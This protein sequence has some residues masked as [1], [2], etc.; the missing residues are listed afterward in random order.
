LL[1]IFMVVAGYLMIKSPP[2]YAENHSS[3]NQ[4]IKIVFIGL[5]LGIIIGLLGAG[6]G[7]LII[8]TLVLLM[9]FTIQEAV[10]TSLFII[11]VNSFIGFAADKHHFIPADWI[12]LAKY[13]IPALL[14]MMMGLY[15][16]KFIKGESL[17]KAFGYFVWIVGMAILTKEFIL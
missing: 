7:F 4:N 10:P 16:A 5:A 6:G 14:G 2:L 17:K 13:L 15:I 12:N 11:T 9:R 8:P 3:K 1:L